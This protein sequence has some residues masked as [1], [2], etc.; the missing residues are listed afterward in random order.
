MRTPFEGADIRAP[1]HAVDAEQASLRSSARGRPPN[2]LARTQHSCH[3]T[4]SSS[5]NQMRLGAVAFDDVGV[6]PTS[7]PIKR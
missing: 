6:N 3:Q 5:G 7:P 1:F 4:Q 2:N